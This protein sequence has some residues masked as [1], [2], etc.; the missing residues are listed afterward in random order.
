MTSRRAGAPVG[1]ARLLRLLYIPRL[2]PGLSA[3]PFLE[4]CGFLDLL[5]VPC[6]DVGNGP[7][8][9][10]SNCLSIQIQSL[11]VV[12]GTWNTG[13]TCFH[14]HSVNVHVLVC[15]LRM[16]KELEERRQ[17]A[18]LQNHLPAKTGPHIR[19]SSLKSPGTWVWLSSP[20]TM[21]PTARSAGVCT[22]GDV[23][24]LASISKQNKKNIKQKDSSHI[25]TLSSSSASKLQEL[26][27]PAA[28]P[29]LAHKNAGSWSTWHITQSP[30]RAHAWSIIRTST[31]RKKRESRSWMTAVMRSLGPSER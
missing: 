14:F 31:E 12:E 17:C 25:P 2:D 3:R 5:A 23:W 1:R 20:V 7:A 21:L 27:Q 10:L 9:L 8:A 22:S 26:H 11:V 15:L 29:S 30:K 16:G 4:P 6:C 28:N 18:T 13:S 24:S 19:A